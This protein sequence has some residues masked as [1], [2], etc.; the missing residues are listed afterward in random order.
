MSTAQPDHVVAERVELR[1]IPLAVARALADPAAD[2]PDEPSWAPGYPLP[3]TRVAARHLVEQ[4]DT[5]AGYGRWGMFQLSLR[6]TGEVI[7]DIGYHGPPDPA[8]TVEIGYGIVEQYRGRGLVGEAA[9]A[10][11]ELTWSR[12]EITRI[13]A[14][15]EQ[16]DGPSGGVL[17]H[18]GFRDD[19]VIDGMRH[20][21]LDR[22]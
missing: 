8:G 7:G 19:G 16:D 17:R 12:P 22:R 5:G 4:A 13:I 18:A 9:V 2:L 21:S 3:G 11:C 1:L 15:T 14:R 6:E 10:I 20:F